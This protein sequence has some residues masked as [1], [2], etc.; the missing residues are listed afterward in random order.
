VV[1]YTDSTRAE[2]AAST[3][4]ASRLI[5]SDLPGDGLPGCS[6]RSHAPHSVRTCSPRNRTPK[7]G[8]CPGATELVPSV[9][10]AQPAVSASRSFPPLSSIRTRRRPPTLYRSHP[11]QSV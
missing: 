3:I 7:Q 5:P 9:V 6:A 4:A 2:A 1:R 11:I 10:P 8:A